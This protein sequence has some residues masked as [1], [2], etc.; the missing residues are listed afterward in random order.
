MAKQFNEAFSD[1]LED[2]YDVMNSS[3]ELRADL[4][5][6]IVNLGIDNDIVENH[7]KLIKNQLTN[8]NSLYHVINRNPT[9]FKSL[10]EILKP[11]A[12]G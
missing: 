8:L 3:A 4:N 6:V 5:E 10:M 12:H 9:K 7:E 11:E 1:W 2:F